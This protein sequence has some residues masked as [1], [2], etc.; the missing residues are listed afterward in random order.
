VWGSNRNGRQNCRLMGRVV[1]RHLRRREEGM[2]EGSW[3]L[4]RLGCQG[5]FYC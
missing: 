3:S 4:S 5:D 2:L 1:I